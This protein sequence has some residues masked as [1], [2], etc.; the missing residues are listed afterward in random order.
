MAARG[1]QG[2]HG[3]R[4]LPVGQPDGRQMAVQVVHRVERQPV[5][6]GDGLGGLHAHQQRADESRP[7]GHGHRTQVAHARCRPGRSASRTTAL[8]RSTCARLATSG[9]TPP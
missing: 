8:M 2:D 7:H 3:K 4:S 5:S 6:P 1:D 9:T